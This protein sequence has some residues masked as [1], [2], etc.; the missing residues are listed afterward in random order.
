MGFANFLH[1][2]IE[3]SIIFYGLKPPSLLAGVISFWSLDKILW[4]RSLYVRG[5]VGF[6][7]LM[8]Y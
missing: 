4:F 6:V 8:R 5:F 7:L 1:L 3:V 2:F